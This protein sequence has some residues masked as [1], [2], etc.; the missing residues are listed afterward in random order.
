MD[1]QGRMLADRVALITGAGR[2]IGRALAVEF[3]RQG[4]IVAVTARSANEIDET[5]E[6]I[7]STSDRAIAIHMDVT[8]AQ[9]V[10][11]GVDRVQRE[12]GRISILINN[13][14]M[15]GPTGPIW[16]NDPSE[17]W[18]T[19]GTHLLGAFLL[20]RAVVPGMIA[21]G[22]GHVLTMASGAALK[23]Q[24]YFSGYGIAKAAQ[25]RLMETL[26]EE[27]RQHGVIA[28]AVSPGLVYTDMIERLI[29]DPDVGEWR[30]EYL[31]RIIEE[32]DHGDHAAAT[33][34][35]TRLCSTLASGHADL[36]SGRHFHPV[37]DLEAE[38]AKA[39]AALQPA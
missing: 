37:H 30:P 8:D 23:P 34:K 13:A 10:W 27:G 19:I 22:G 35:V 16:E 21:Q 31:E 9:A 7:T 1:M 25:V 11:S 18:R 12:L 39:R 28:F 33:E 36:L 3:A 15:A 2:G 20:T 6:Q 4:A 38:L 17:W 29:D 5:V 32:R 14:G 26:A 24:S